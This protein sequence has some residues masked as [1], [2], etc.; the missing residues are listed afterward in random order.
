MNAHLD[1]RRLLLAIGSSI[2]LAAAAAHAGDANRVHIRAA[3]TNFD[4][5]QVRV[6]YADLNLDSSAGAAT[7]YGRIK[8]AAEYACGAR[9]GNVEMKLTRDWNGC[10]ELAIFDAVSRVDNGKLTAHH[11]AN[12]GADHA[13]LLARAR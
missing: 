12:G 2:L 1:S 3:A 6:S 11:R 7:L 10:R 4:P 13:A 8:A 9:P 5:V